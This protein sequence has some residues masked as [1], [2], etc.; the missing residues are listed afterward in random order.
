M[1]LTIFHSYRFNEIYV[2]ALILQ[3]TVTD[4]EIVELPLKLSMITKY[5][6][7]KDRIEYL[8]AS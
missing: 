4:Y 2:V 1:I 5:S 6:T 3:L 7:S 8:I